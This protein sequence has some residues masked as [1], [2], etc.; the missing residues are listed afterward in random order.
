MMTTS[1][2]LGFWNFEEGE[3]ETVI[4]LSGNGNDG[5][6]NGATYSVNVPE[7]SCQL[8]TVNGCDSTAVFYPF[9]T[10]PDTSYVNIAVCIVLSGMG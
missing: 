1:N 8:T 2:A 4:D 6:I 9:I 7:Q 10:Q 3:G 5:I